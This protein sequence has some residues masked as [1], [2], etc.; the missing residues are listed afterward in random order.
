MNRTILLTGGTGFLGSHLGYQ[1]LKR[2]GRVIYL[3]RGNRGH[4]ARQRVELLLRHLDPDHARTCPGSFEIWEGDVTQPGLGLDQDAVA[5]WRGKIDEVWH[6]AAVLHF[7]ENLE[8]L[9]ETINIQ[10]TVNVLDA[11]HA[12]GVRRFH[13]ISTAYVSG[14]AEG[15]VYEEKAAFTSFRNPYERTKHDAELRVREKSAV[16]GLDTTI[17]RPAVIVG[18][19]RTGDTMSFTGFYNLAKVF[20]LFKR[21]LTR[22]IKE[23]PELCRGAGVYTDGTG[24]HFPLRFP[25]A[26]QGTVNMIP[27]DYVVDTIMKL[28]GTAEASGQTFHITHP[29]PPHIVELFTAGC[30]MIGLH[31]IEFVDCTFT[32]ALHIIHD[33]IKRYAR[34]G[35]NISFCLEIREYIHYLFGEP[36]FDIS[37]VRKTLRT[38]FH[39]PPRIT[40][41]FLRML[42]D[43]ATACQW[44][45]PIV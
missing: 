35:V 7:R 16:Y 24:V 19:S 36:M 18:D 3:A 26:R 31:G 39:E 32:E 20:Y 43:F 6:S 40:P 45:S 12:L 29:D 10:G 27:V 21:L 4:S 34:L 33:E 44:K 23:N 11:A 1:F 17:Y 14:T 42:L 28:S 2:G 8:P 37:N 22:K 41:Q 5:R 25:C 15:T 9:T 13:H 38:G 30:R